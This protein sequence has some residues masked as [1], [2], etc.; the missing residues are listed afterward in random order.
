MAYISLFLAIH[1]GDWHLRIASLKEMVPLF[2]TF[3]HPT[4]QKL[5]SKHIADLFNLPESIM[6][7]LSQGVFVLN[8]TGRE[9][10][11][12]A[13][14]EG[15]EM[16]INKQCKNA[17]VKPMED[18]M[19]RMATY[20]TYRT[21]TLQKFKEQLFPSSFTKT[22]VIR[23]VFSFKPV[24]KIFEYNVQSQMKA[25]SKVSFLP[26]AEVSRGLLN[27]F[28]GAEATNQQ[29]YDLLN[30]RHIG[31]E[32]YKLR[33]SYSILK[34]PSM[35][36]PNRRKALQAFS[37]KQVKTVRVSQLE[38]DKKLCISYEKKKFSF[39]EKFGKQVDKPE[40]QLYW[41]I[42]SQ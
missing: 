11:S 26:L 12:V 35:R 13:I 34:E 10:H 32:E 39:H 16:L 14:D 23:S 18:Y 8:I 40:E 33:I 6:L 20:L 36:A 30:F 42:P 37:I 22:A 15:H 29:H 19:K 38:K 41:N 1:S 2:T 24:D 25:L 27:L 21:R 7:M 5:I 4:Y 9:W 3:D 17:V 28:N 31:E